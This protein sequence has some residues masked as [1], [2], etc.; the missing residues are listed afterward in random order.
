[1]SV[2]QEVVTNAAAAQPQQ[3]TAAAGRPVEYWL[4]KL[5]YRL[6]EEWDKKSVKTGA[7]LGL[8]QSMKNKVLD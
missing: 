5:P 2:K 3:Q 1:M 4:V 6:E 8:P 7:L